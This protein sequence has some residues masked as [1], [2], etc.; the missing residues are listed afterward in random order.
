MFTHCIQSFQSR[1]EQTWHKLSP[2]RLQK[3]FDWCL[4]LAK[5][6]NWWNSTSRSFSFCFKSTC[7]S[8][9]SLPSIISYPS[10]L[11]NYFLSRAYLPTRIKSNP[12]PS[13][14]ISREL[15]HHLELEV[16]HVLLTVYSSTAGRSWFSFLLGTQDMELSQH[17]SNSLSQLLQDSDQLLHCSHSMLSTPPP[18]PVAQCLWD[19]LIFVCISETSPRHQAG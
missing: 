19:Y 11:F 10:P 13:I 4:Y 18:L 12:G 7:L 8:F 15:A 16:R 9:S 17:D 5:V 14:C 6:W 3:I 2:Q 1:I